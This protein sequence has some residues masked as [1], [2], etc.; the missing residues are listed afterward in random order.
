MMEITYWDKIQQQKGTETFP[1]KAFCGVSGRISRSTPPALQSGAFALLCN[2]I[3][4]G[5]IQ[6][7]HVV[8]TELEYEYVVNRVRGIPTKSRLAGD[9]IPTFFSC[10]W[11][12]ETAAMILLN[13]VA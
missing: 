5:N 13:L 12:G 10:E 3:R 1:D 7:I 6:V 11:V 4:K 8:A 9:P 2:Q